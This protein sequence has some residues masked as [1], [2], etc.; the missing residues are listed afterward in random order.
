MPS[1]L[2][3]AIGKSGISSNAVTASVLAIVLFGRD[4]VH[5]RKFVSLFGRDTVLFGRDKESLFGRDVMT[6]ISS[7]SS[8]HLTKAA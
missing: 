2:S 5:E 3:N 8:F 4:K 1:Q 7:I 6:T